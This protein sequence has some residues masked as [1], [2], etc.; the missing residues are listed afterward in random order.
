MAV[1]VNRG[2]KKADELIHDMNYRH[3]NGRHLYEVYGKCSQKKRN[4]W[5]KICGE[6]TRL[7]GEKLHIVGANCYT[8][9]CIYAYRDGDNMI[10]R[11]ITKGG[12][13]ELTLPIEEYKE[14]IR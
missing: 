9:S 3:P 1:V 5:E 12:T 2:T 14:I 11:K 10:I 4:S 13:Y 6:C 8:Y 7:N